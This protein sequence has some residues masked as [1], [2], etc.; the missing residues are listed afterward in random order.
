MKKIL[1]LIACA[2]QFI[3]CNTDEKSVSETKQQT[4]T[5]PTPKDKS[6]EA[7][8]WLMQAIEKYFN[9]PESNYQTITTPQYYEYKN[10][11]TNVDLDGGMTL[12]AFQT[13]WNT[14]YDTK[15]AGVGVGFFISGQDYGKISVTKCDAIASSQANQYRFDVQIDDT[16]MKAK[17]HREIVLVEVNNSFLIDDVKE[18]E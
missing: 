1:V 9:T 17:Y 2:M 13:K 3:A 16:E 12:Q 18:F 8:K 4:E 11:A 6:T 7:K 5:T 15:Y 14:K 10:D